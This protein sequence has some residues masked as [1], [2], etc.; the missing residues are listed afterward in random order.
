MYAQPYKRKDDLYL[1]FVSNYLLICC[2]V[3]G[4]VLHLCE[5]EDETCQKFI[6][7]NLNSYDASIVVICITIGMTI[8]SILFLVIIAMNTIKTPKVKISDDTVNLELPQ[9]CVRHVYVS[10]LPATSGDK[11]RAIA[12]KLKQFLPGMEIAC[13]Y[14]ESERSSVIKQNVSESAVFVIVYGNGEYAREWITWGLFNQYYL[15][16]I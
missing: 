9:D 11:A 14:D 16:S 15:I 4:I 5:G 2:F 3:T 10:F 7:M 13:G 8:L 12:L 6:G 1:A